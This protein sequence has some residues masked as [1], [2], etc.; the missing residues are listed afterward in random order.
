MAGHLR[1]RH[2]WIVCVAALGV[3]LALGWP[4]L[5]K[6]TAGASFR[7]APM[8][9]LWLVPFTLFGAALL[10]SMALNLRPTLKWTLLCVEVAAV[11]VMAIIVP[12]AGMSEFLV[13]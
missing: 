4:T 5:Q 3:W 9:A 8:S 2:H 6:L 1:N 10:G 11:V 12:W 7:G 13:I